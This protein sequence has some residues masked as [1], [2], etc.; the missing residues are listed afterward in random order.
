MSKTHARRVQRNTITYAQME[1]MGLWDDI[2]KFVKKYKVVSRVLGAAGLAAKFVPIP[3][4]AAASMPLSIAGTAAG[5]A[6]YGMHGGAMSGKGITKSQLDAIRSGLA[7]WSPSGG[8]SMAAAKYM[9]PKIKN[10]LP[11]QVRS[12]AAGLGRMVKSGGLSLRGGKH[13]GMYSKGCMRRLH[14]KPPPRMMRIKPMYGRGYSGR[15]Y[16]GRGVV[17]PGS[18]PG[19]GT[20]LAGSGRRQGQK[21]K[22]TYRPAVMGPKTVYRY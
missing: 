13:S 19:K 16:S 9:H 20:R 12:L 4:A 6:G 8:I 7:M 18:M 2:K 5:L 21:K 11:A 3:G 1:G 22:R 15:G 14:P 10:I 17:L